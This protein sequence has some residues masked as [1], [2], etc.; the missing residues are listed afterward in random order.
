[1]SFETNSMLG[2]NDYG[3]EL[4]KEEIGKK[5]HRHFVGGLW[6]EIGQLQFNFLIN[7]RLKPFHK[8]LDVGCGCLRGGLHFIKYLNEGNYYGLDIN[9]SLIQAGKLEVKEAGLEYKCPKLL[10]DD[11][12]RIERF[13]IKFDFMISISLFTHLPINIIIRCLSEVKKYL[14]PDGIYFSSIFEAPESVHLDT[15]T[16][17]SGVTTNYDSDP[18]HYSFKEILWMANIVGLKL[19]RIGDWGH[20]RNHKMVAFSQAG[21]N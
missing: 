3:K 21:E 13:G 2:I 16:H 17:P 8:L 10:V 18:F 1:M 7:Q 4:T 20:P 5:V 15:L 19:I 12:F 14:K 9:A 6:H 11:K